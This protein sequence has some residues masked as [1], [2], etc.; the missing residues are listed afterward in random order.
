MDCQSNEPNMLHWK[1]LLLWLYDF[2]LFTAT[3][4]TTIFTLCPLDLLPSCPSWPLNFSSPCPLFSCLFSHPHRCPS[5]TASFLAFEPVGGLRGGEHYARTSPTRRAARASWALSCRRG[6]WWARVPPAV[7]A[8]SL[9][10]LGALR[11]R[12]R[13]QF[14]TEQKRGIWLAIPCQAQESLG[15]IWPVQQ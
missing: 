11:L 9:R 4:T 2:A 10:G 14:A 6:W 8:A 3:I 1:Q 7:L 13:P 5:T 12:V 15:A